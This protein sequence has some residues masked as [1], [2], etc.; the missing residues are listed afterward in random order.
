MWSL[1]WPHLLIINKEKTLL[2][3]IVCNTVICV[4]L[5]L[6][7]VFGADAEEVLSTK[8]T[9]SAFLVGATEVLCEKE[10]GS[11]EEI[12]LVE[13]NRDYYLDGKYRAFFFEIHDGLG[14][15]IK[16]CSALIIKDDDRCSICLDGTE[17]DAYVKLV[18]EYLRALTA[19]PGF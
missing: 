12:K 14:N 7:T 19:A 1:C 8:E 2:I 9:G 6:R 11:A 5:F 4:G 10:T 18:L 15:V 13:T 16:K 3:R 17:E